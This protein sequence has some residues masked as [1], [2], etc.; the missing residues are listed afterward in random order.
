M[1]HTLTELTNTSSALDVYHVCTTYSLLKTHECVTCVGKLISCISPCNTSYAVQSRLYPAS[2][3][4]SPRHLAS[5]SPI[6]SSCA[7][8]RLCPT[9]L[10][11]EPTPTS[12]LTTTKVA[13]SICGICTAVVTETA[14][15]VI[16]VSTSV[17][18][19]TISLRSTSVTC[20]IRHASCL[21]LPRLRVCYTMVHTD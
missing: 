16:S 11:V 2:R 19:T 8:S 3:A 10:A 14:T 13:T 1:S 18:L 4:Y 6:A 7:S 20:T 5:S 21:L 12:R 17:A 9:E 15:T